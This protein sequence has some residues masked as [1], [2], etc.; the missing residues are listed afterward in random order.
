MKTLFNYYIFTLVFTLISVSGF[1]QETPEVEAIPFAV[2]DQAPAFPGC[3]SL[4]G[5]EMKSCTVDKI[6]HYVNANFNTTLGKELNIIGTTRIVVQFKID[7]TGNIIDVRS[8]S[9]ADKANVRE[10]LQVEADRVVSSLPQMQPGKKDGKNVA[11][12]YSLPIAF[13]VPEKEE[14]KG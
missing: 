8:R 13:A 9:L 10:A 1:S 3:D 11:I 6:T 7:E 4:E 2:A 14:K 12:M 5:E